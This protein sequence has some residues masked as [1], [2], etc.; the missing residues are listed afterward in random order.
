M[1][2]SPT[3]MPTKL[4]KMSKSNCACV[5]KDHPPRSMT[6]PINARN[7]A[8]RRQQLKRIGP[9][10]RMAGGEMMLLNATLSAAHSAVTS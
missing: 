8:P 9:R 6:N 4:D 10:C 1:N 2:E 5:G 3:M 7:A